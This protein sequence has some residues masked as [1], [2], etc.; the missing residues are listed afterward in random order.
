[1]RKIIT[2]MAFFA[3]TLLSTNETIAQENKKDIKTEAK[4]FTH[5]LTQKFKLNGDNQRT[6]YHAYL[7]KERKLNELNNPNLDKNEAEKKAAIINT[8]FDNKVKAIL[9]ETQYK[10]YLLKKK[11]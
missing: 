8:E 6:I 2:V 7:L 5:D 4:L 3:V 9:N 1:M 11:K 10:E